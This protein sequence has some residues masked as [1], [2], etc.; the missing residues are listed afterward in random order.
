[1]L[2]DRRSFVARV[3]KVTGYVARHG[4]ALLLQLQLLV[5]WVQSVA[6]PRSPPRVTGTSLQTAARPPAA[7]SFA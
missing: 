1:M 7:P 5:H 4:S 3:T 6:R 2:A